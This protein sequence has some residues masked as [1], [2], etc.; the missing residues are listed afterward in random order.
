MGLPKRELVEYVRMAEH[1]QEV[2]EETLKQQAENVKDWMPVVRCKDCAY[3]VFDEASQECY[4]NHTF[5]MYGDINDIDF[6]SYG[7]R[8]ESR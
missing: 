2:A 3:K 5:G 4:C 7:E 6:C 8:K 1:N